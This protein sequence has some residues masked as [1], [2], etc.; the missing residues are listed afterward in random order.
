M[1]MKIME[2]ARS[3]R[4]HDGFPLHFWAFFVDIVVYFINRGPSISLDG[5]ITEE[6]WTRINLSRNT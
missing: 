5:G 2:C 3:M 4:F 1:N 6:V